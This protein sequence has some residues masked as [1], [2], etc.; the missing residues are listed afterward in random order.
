MPLHPDLHILPLTFERDGQLNTLNLSLIVDPDHGL[1]LVDTGLP[2]MAEQLSAA[3]AAAGYTVDQITRIIITHQDRDHIGSLPEL[4]AATGAPVLAHPLEEPYIDGRS[5]P[6]KFAMFRQRPGGE[7]MVAEMIRQFRPTPVN[8]L[9]NDDD[10]LD[11]AGGVRVIFTPGHSPGHICLYLERSRI[12]IAGDAL[13]ASNGTL[14]GPNPPVTP[15]MPAALR[16]VQKLA[17]FDVA[18]IVC[19]HGGVV[20]EDANGQLRRVAAAAPAAE[21]S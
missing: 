10:R 17:A 1:T 16:S 18:A 3:I 19:Y 5:E 7:A 4:A 15:D 2:G 13:T 21:R 20:Q 9:L 6:L 14:N 12:L 11:I 8:Q